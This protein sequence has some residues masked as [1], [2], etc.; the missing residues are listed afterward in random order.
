MGMG[1][2]TRLI[3][4]PLKPYKRGEG[5]LNDWKVKEICGIKIVEDKSLPDYEWKLVYPHKQHIYPHER[6]K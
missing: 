3:E 1:V 6:K 5:N 4:I 2:D